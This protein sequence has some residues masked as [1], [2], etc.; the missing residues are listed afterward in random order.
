MMASFEFLSI[1]LEFNLERKFF[2][3]G[4][5]CAQIS[6]FLKEYKNDS[7]NV[8]GGL[9]SIETTVIMVIIVW[10]ERKHRKL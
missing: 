8:V 5:V 2:Y 10:Q 7:I 9:N 3:L 6:Y 4:G 1:S